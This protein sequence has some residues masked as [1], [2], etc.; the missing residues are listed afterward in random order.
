MGQKTP[1]SLLGVVRTPSARNDAA[2]ATPLAIAPGVRAT[3]R[4]LARIHAELD[5]ERAQSRTAEGPS[6]T[7]HVPARRRGGDAVRRAS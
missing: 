3:L 6:T 1:H 2:S 4:L 5:A 7:E